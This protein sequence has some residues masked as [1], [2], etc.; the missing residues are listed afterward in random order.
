MAAPE[1]I[2]A[3]SRRVNIVYGIRMPEQR[4]I[5]LAIGRAVLSSQHPRIWRVSVRLAYIGLYGKRTLGRLT[6]RK[7]MAVKHNAMVT[8]LP[9]QRSG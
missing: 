6:M 3:A 4:G 2:P 7:E 5:H 1:Q 9:H 8:L